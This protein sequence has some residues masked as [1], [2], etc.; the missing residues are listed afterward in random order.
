MGTLKKYVGEWTKKTARHLLTRTT[1]GPSIEM[2]NESFIIGLDETMNRLFLRVNSPSPP[3]KSI[4][5]GTGN[6]QLDD[7]G[8]KYGE[9]WINAEPFPNVNP[10]MFRNRVLRSRS[11]SLYS[12]TLLQM[13]SSG[14]SITEKL[15][16]FWHN[17]F[18]TANSVIPHR[19]YLYYNLLR[20]SAIGNFKELTKKITIDTNMLLYLSG[21][22][23]TN[24]APN[25]NYSRELLE[26]FTIGKGEL[27]GQGDYTNYTEYDVVEMAK[28]LTGWRV[29]PVSSS[30]TLTAE[31]DDN[32]HTLG[33]KKLS[34][35]FDDTIIK[36]NGE[37][38]YKNL[39][40]V[41]FQKKECSLFIIRKFYR[42]FVGYDI[43]ED[44]ELN[45]IEPLALELRQNDFE[46]AFPLRT[47]FTSE[48]FFEMTNCMVKNP[49]D[50]M[51]SAS[52]GLG[53]TPPKNNVE[54]EYDYAYNL[55]I[56]ASDLEQSLFYHPNVAG[57]KAYY[58][59]PQYYKLWINN[60]LLPK[61][62]TFCQL[63][64]EGGSFSY[65]DVNYR[66]S[67]LIPVLDLADSIYGAD[68]PNSL[69]LGLSEVL[70]SYPVSTNQISQLKEILIPGLPDFEWSVEYSEYKSD[71]N[72]EE[73]K[74]AIENKLK[75]LLSIMVRMSEFQIM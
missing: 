75:R 19:E 40:D 53:V 24:K 7:P 65:K 18:V 60:L 46:I 2:V 51:M 4:P 45:I 1:F 14:I 11:K 59:E 55:Y 73:N 12:W 63:M 61:R 47:L 39:I 68:D 67:S 37:D 32:R 29:R 49:I 23:N 28:V 54:L 69:I 56:M 9:T 20:E 21:A 25:E 26:L 34:H 64:V 52:R 42:W 58:Q 66:V 31:F 57:W 43:D 70:F 16:L 17:H 8:S 72:N 30:N 62:Q 74:L 13:H 5:D 41:I 71:P 27:V 22:E 15:T 6:N 36:E 50:L 44:I 48:H 35:R 38:E 3:L 33:D 10:P